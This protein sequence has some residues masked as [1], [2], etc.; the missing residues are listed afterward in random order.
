MYSK[1]D[2]HRHIRLGLLLPAGNTTFEP[3]FHSAFS[4]QVSIH[5]H[6]VIAQGSHPY[7]TYESMDDINEEAV[8]EISKLE[9]QLVNF[10]CDG[11]L[12]DS[13]AH[14][15]LYEQTLNQF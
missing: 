2:S 15:A 13:E 5:S 1:A 14:G 9:T 12:V 6:R 7:E 10:D 11:V 4:S 3:D 8:K